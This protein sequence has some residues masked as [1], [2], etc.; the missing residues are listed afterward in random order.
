MI[1]LPC[2]ILRIR[3]RRSQMV[4]ALEIPQLDKL[5]WVVLIS[6]SPSPSPRV[7]PEAKGEPLAPDSGTV[8][9]ILSVI[10]VAST[11]D[12]FSPFCE[13]LAT[14]LHERCAK[15]SQQR[16]SSWQ[17]TR[18]STVWLN[19]FYFYAIQ[20]VALI[21]LKKIKIAT[22]NQWLDYDYA[23]LQNPTNE[24]ATLQNSKT[25]EILYLDTLACIVLI[26]FVASMRDNRSSCS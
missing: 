19:C 13:T 22:E 25:L 2:K 7:Q 12:N 8:V 5:A 16:P 20:S 9:L 4:K 1:M 21:V 3:T 10:F 18:L 23:S 11:G 26:P 6:L 24:N 14:V 15:F 17:I